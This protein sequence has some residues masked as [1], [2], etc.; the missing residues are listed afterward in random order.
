LITPAVRSGQFYGNLRT[1]ERVENDKHGN[2]RWACLCVCCGRVSIT[3]RERLG[4]VESCG[5]VRDARIRSHGETGEPT[6]SSWMAMKYRCNDPNNASYCYYGARGIKVC[7]RWLDSYANFLSDMGHKPHGCSLD[8][9][10]SDGNYDPLN[11]RW[12]T[13]KE[14]ARNRRT[15]AKVDAK[16][17]N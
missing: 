14:Q 2:I 4:L 3:R 16:E 10:D 7:E 6:Y 5:C 13:F 9:I 11:C 12:A 1:I 15:R 17:I 8:R